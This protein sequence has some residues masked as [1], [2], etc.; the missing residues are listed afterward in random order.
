MTLQKFHATSIGQ[1]Q[2]SALSGS[3]EVKTGLV[4]TI[5]TLIAIL[6]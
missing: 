3:S 6:F 1:E 5:T 4:V 2:R